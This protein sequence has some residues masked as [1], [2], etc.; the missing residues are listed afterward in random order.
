[1][2]PVLVQSD[3]DPPDLLRAALKGENHVTDSGPVARGEMNV[4]GL[5]LVQ[6][7]LQERGIRYADGCEGPYPNA[8]ARYNGTRPGGQIKFGNGP[9]RG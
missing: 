7:R 9:A 1:M 2:E 3:G 8:V 6:A 4:L 5:C